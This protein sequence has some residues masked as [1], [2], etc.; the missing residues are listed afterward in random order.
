MRVYVLLNL[1]NGKPR[2]LSL[3]HNEFNKGNVLL[4]SEISLKVIC[5]TAKLS[6][7]YFCNDFRDY[8]WTYIYIIQK[9]ILCCSNRG[10]RRD[11]YGLITLKIAFWYYTFNWMEVSYFINSTIVFYHRRM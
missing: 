8:E 3:F 10:Q 6:N 11:K 7:C 5:E 2:I 9:H 1:L 4:R